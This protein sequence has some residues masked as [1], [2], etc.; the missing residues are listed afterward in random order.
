MAEDT[1]ALKVQPSDNPGL[2]LV[3]TLLDGTNF[4]SWSRSIKLGLRTKMKLSFISADIKKP[5][6]NTKEME[7]WD[8]TDSMVTSWILNSI[9]REIVESFMYTNSARELWVELENRFEQSNGPLEYRLKKELGALTQG[10]LTL[11]NYF[12]KLKKLW[13]ELAC[14]TYTPK[15]TCGAAK[16]TSEIEEHDQTIQF[17][18]GLNDVYDHVRNHILIMEPIPAAY[19]KP[20][21][22]KSLQK[23]RN[24][25][26]KRQLICKECGKSGHLK[27]ACFEI[28]GYPEW[29]KA[30]MEQRKWNASTTNKAVATIEMKGTGNNAVD[31]QT[32]ARMF[33]NVFHKFLGG[34]KPQTS[35]LKDEDRYD[36]S[37]IT[38]HLGNQAI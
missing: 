7:Q 16:E 26:D 24:L 27:E 33:R 32:I 14:I 20:E 28:H 36:F 18:M 8:R 25:Q 15:C 31:E 6:E 30:L 34:L 2:V 13:D 1:N 5:E 3:T 35:H 12:G 21:F 4:L 38:S 9:S 17:L 22:Q 19:K 11:S 29:Y 10:S 37:G 23:N